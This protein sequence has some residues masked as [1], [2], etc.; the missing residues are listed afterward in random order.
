MEQ[1]AHGAASSERDEEASLHH[2]HQGPASPE[3]PASEGVVS[4]RRG[5]HAG[6]AGKGSERGR[7]AV[8]P[9]VARA[10][11]HR[12]EPAARQVPHGDDMCSA[13]P[14]ALE[15]RRAQEVVE[16]AAERAAAVVEAEAAA[17]EAERRR[18]RLDRLHGVRGLERADYQGQVAP[19]WLGNFRCPPTLACDLLRP[20]PIPLA[21]LAH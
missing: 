7:L 13:S 1:A 17:A 11:M 16:A 3:P 2:A 10:L 18:A 19:A 12:L 14:G 8:P 5:A 20:A 4:L 9:S 6:K 21:P 15:P